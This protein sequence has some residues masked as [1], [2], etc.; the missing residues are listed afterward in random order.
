M[1]FFWAAMRWFIG[2]YWMWLLGAGIVIAL[3]AKV[4]IWRGDWDE[5]KIVKESAKKTEALGV[6]RNRPADAGTVVKRLRTG[7]F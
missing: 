7:T 2:K 5:A 4:W 1:T 3:C 6:I